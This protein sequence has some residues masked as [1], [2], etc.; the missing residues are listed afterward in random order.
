MRRP[1]SSSALSLLSSLVGGGHK[2]KRVSLGLLLWL[3][4]KGQMRVRQR[5]FLGRGTDSAWW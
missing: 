4:R 5:R 1:S 2:G 3:W